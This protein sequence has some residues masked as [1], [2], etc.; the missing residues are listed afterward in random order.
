MILCAR[1]DAGTSA[2]T[3]AD[4]PELALLL[5]CSRVRIS[6]EDE[7]A[8]RL[9]LQA[10]IDWTAFARRAIEHGLACLAGKSLAS[11]APDLVPDDILDAF[12]ALITHASRANTTAFDELTRIIEALRKVGIDAIPLKGPTLAIQ[13][14]GDIGLRSFRDM[15]FLIR[16]ADLKPAVML[17]NDLG[18][19]RDQPLTETQIENIQ[20]LN[21]QDFL[22]SRATGI[23]FEPHT[24]LTPI[25]MALDIDYAG[26]WRRAYRTILN[27]RQFL[28]L[29]PEDTFVVLA[30]HGGKEMWWNLKWPCDIAAFIESHPDLDW[31]AVMERARAQGCLRMVLL[32]TAM[33]QKHFQSKIPDAISG[34]QRA[35]PVI[36][37]MV[38]RVAANWS[39][40]Q[41]TGP[42][43]HKTISWDRFLL[44]DRNWQRALYVTRTLFLP[45]PHHVAAIP[46]PCGLLG[47]VPVKLAHDLIALPLWRVWR[48][49]R[50]K[51]A[52]LN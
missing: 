17:L 31:T 35:D 6:Q 42:P 2:L 18:Y 50:R 3:T 5:A 43:T 40:E 41:L 52:L 48:N 45:G 25:K 49:G 46:L 38:G 9:L 1:S 13:A 20:R 11:A 10:G 12:S 33:A 32:A 19:D 26:L 27:G 14:Y 29:S 21:G 23:V 8:I 39:A 36:D 47:Y 28:V 44:H 22:F 30:I 24:R 7:R 34:A 16:D 4:A 37:P 51:A 15:D